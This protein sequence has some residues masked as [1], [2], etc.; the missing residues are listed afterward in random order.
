[1]SEMSIDVAPE[2]MIDLGGVEAAKSLGGYEPLPRGQYEAQWE[3]RELG[4]TTN[5]NPQ[6]EGQWIVQEGEYAGRTVRDWVVFTTKSAAFIKARMQAMKIRMPNQATGA[7]ELAQYFLRESHG[8][9]AKI[10]LTIKESQPD[11]NGRTYQNN[12]VVG[13]APAAGF[14]PQD[15]ATVSQSELESDTTF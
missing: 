2:Q 1:M 14:S 4:T 10:T 15:G 5:G 8:K 13:I 3:A 11:E 9:L 6:V 7:T 12:K